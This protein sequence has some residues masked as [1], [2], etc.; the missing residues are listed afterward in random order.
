LASRICS[1][2]FRAAAASRSR[3]A[4][5]EGVGMS[6]GPGRPGFRLLADHTPPELRW[7]RCRSVLLRNLIWRADRVRDALSV[8][9]RGRP[10]LSRSGAQR[11]CPC[12]AATISHFT[13][14]SSLDLSAAL[15]PGPVAVL[16]RRQDFEDPQRP[17]KD[18][19]AE[20]QALPVK[21]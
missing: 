16:F 17:V 5:R 3:A 4:S 20:Q 7:R 11:E 1:S 9:V 14:L 13:G 10:R 6:T 18:D 15:T 8:H 21:P 12:R 19:P 2:R